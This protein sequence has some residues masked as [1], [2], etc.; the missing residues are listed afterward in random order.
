MTVPS[1]KVFC[2]CALLIVVP[3]ESLNLLLGFLCFVC[4]VN[5]GDVKLLFDCM[6]LILMNMAAKR[7]VEFVFD[8]LEFDCEIVVFLLEQAALIVKLLLL[9][10]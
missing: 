5:P 6:E 2:P 3:A 4:F 10:F 9:S 1:L 7:A 8:V